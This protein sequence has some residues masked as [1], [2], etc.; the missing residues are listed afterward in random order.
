MGVEATAG[1]EKKTEDFDGLCGR[2]MC[3]RF[4]YHA[5]ACSRSLGKEPR[6][7]ILPLLRWLVDMGRSHRRYRMRLS[8]NGEPLPKPA[9]PPNQGKDLEL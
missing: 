7:D 2:P 9:R 3:L 4:Q 8:T 6:P 5:L 1:Y